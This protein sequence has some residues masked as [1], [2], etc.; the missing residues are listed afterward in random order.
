MK[1]RDFEVLI[2]A[3]ACNTVRPAQ[4]LKYGILREIALYSL[5]EYLEP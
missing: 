3:T 5:G 1:G 4:G 2:S